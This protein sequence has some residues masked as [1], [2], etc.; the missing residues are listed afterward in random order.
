MENNNKLIETYQTNFDDLVAKTMPLVGGNK[1]EAEDIVQDVFCCQLINC[2]Y[3]ARDNA[4]MAT[5]IFSIIKNKVCDMHR[6]N[7]RYKYIAYDE[8]E[9]IPAPAENYFTDMEMEEEQS[10]RINV[11]INAKKNLNARQAQVIDMFY[12]ENK[13]QKEIAHA[14]GTTTG[15]VEQL[16]HRAKEGIKKTMQAA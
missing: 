12:W 10:E 9:N 6:Y 2:K 7:T 11:M 16:L 15:A 3:E 5:Y 4:S 13:N 8:E 1:M 14:L